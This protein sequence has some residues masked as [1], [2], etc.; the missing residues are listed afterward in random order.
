MNRRSFVKNSSLALAGLSIAPSLLAQSGPHPFEGRNWFWLN[1]SSRVPM[2]RWKFLFERLSTAGFTGVLCNASDQFYEEM[3]PVFKSFGMTLHAWRW[4][5][6]RSYYGKD[7]P[8]WY[9][10]N[11]NG[12]SVLDE[13]PYVGY[14]RWMCPSNDSV[15]QMLADD[16]AKLTSIS[17]LSGVHL[18]YVRYCDVS[19]A[20][21]L[22]PKYGLVQDHEMPEYDYC[23]CKNC[24]GKFANLHGYDPL[25]RP[26]PAGDSTWHQFRLD[27]VVDLVHGIVEAVHSKGSLISGA[28][29]PTPDMSRRMVRQ[30][31]SRFNLDAYMPMLY[32]QYYL[33]DTHWISK[34]IAEARQEVSAETPIF[35]GMMVGKRSNAQ[36]LKDTHDRVVEAGGNGI[37]VFTGWGLSDEMLSLFR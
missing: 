12:D 19:L 3:A 6:N 4:T 35:A 26:D 28:V 18:D 1:G 17:G 34:S 9:A 36:L 21:G 24:R 15:R 5:L 37:S 31:W 27:Q 16:Y 7:H 30:D 8:D 29:F 25:E 10:V 14:Y 32:H 13:P 2:D 11:R 23:Y 20:P 22:Q 33:E